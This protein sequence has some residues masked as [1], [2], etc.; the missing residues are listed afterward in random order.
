MTT[1]DA[2]DE[3]RPSFDTPP[4]IKKN[5][6]K[7]KK[8]N[9]CTKTGCGCKK[10]DC[11]HECCMARR[12][13]Q[14]DIQLTLL[15]EALRQAQPN[16]PAFLAISGCL[17]KCGFK[18]PAAQDDVNDGD[19]ADSGGSKPPVAVAAA[20]DLVAITALREEMRSTQSL[21]IAARRQE[22][23]LTR[24]LERI[25]PLETSNDAALAMEFLYNTQ[26]EATST[27]MDL[28]FQTADAQCRVARFNKTLREA[29][30]TRAGWDDACHKIVVSISDHYLTTAKSTLNKCFVQG[31][32]EDPTQYADRV[33]HRIDV[34][35]YFA[36]IVGKKADMEELTRTWI[37]GLHQEL[38]P[39]VWPKVSA[40]SGNNIREAL[41]LAK[42][43]H[44]SMGLGQAQPAPMHQLGQAQ[45]APM[46]QLGLQEDPPAPAM[47]GALLQQIMEHHTTTMAQM[48]EERLQAFKPS[49]G[50]NQPTKF[51]CA[52]P[53]CKGALHRF[54]DC[55]HKQE[56]R[57]C[58]KYGHHSEACFTQRPELRPNFGP[59][60]RGEH[61][62]GARPPYRPVSP[63]RRHGRDQKGGRDASPKRM[64]DRDRD[65]DNG[66]R[67]SDQ[68]DRGR[69]KDRE[70][71]RDR[72]RDRSRDRDRR[73]DHGKR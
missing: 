3:L 32:L 16:T 1:A 52:L 51:P 63:S 58:P 33:L 31:R 14:K 72:S 15:S 8:G 57:H 48:I 44:E 5:S 41:K 42:S 29:P 30:R 17:T 23:K 68:S 65:R 28:T 70:R 34:Y 53:R 38:R 6:K 39:F 18:S 45:P 50:F 10:P 40:G 71:D 62:T 61:G 47:D 73:E 4:P 54:V 20:A 37:M 19:D 21:Q 55:P 46:H 13:S 35:N 22:R 25:V 69:D 59:L 36:R 60:K 67:G 2:S 24:I 56:C 26:Y 43:T 9:R 49:D 7:K 66:R 27:D 64:D 12:E 11:D